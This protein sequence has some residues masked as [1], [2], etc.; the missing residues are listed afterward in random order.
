MTAEI[1]LFYLFAFLVCAGAISVAVSQSIVRMAFSLVLTLG[2]TAVLFLLLGADFV[3][4]TQLLVYV[5]GTLVLLVFGVM[6][7][8]T[9]PFTRIK[10]SAA[11]GILSGLIGVVFLF[12]VA[13]TVTSVDWDGGK[14]VAQKI[15]YG[16]HAKAVEGGFNPA[17]QGNTTRSLGLSFLSIRADR[18]LRPGVPPAVTEQTNATL[19]VPGAPSA[20]MPGMSPPPKSPA[21]LSTGYLL[22]FEIVSVHLLVVLVGAAYLARTKRRAAVRS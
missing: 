5:G 11:D 18:D 15:A 6:L 20:A 22:P 1:I 8:A 12:I 14:G 17:Q 7:T 9:G 13:S 19:V 4:A 2:S 16:S 10:S 3:G 21:P